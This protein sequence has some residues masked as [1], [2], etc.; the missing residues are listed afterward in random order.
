M[1]ES[2]NIE[3]YVFKVLIPDPDDDSRSVHD[4]VNKIYCEIMG[5]ST[6]INAKNCPSQTAIED[7]IKSGVSNSECNEIIMSLRITP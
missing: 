5:I 2:N 4:N 6:H 3:A 1:A 7:A